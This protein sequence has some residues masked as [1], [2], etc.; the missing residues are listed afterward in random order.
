MVTSNSNSVANRFGYGG[1]ELQEGLGLEIY[2]FGARF[3]DPSLGRWFVVDALADQPEQIDKS[4]YA[5]GW[6]NPIFY[7]DPD[8][9]CPWCIIMQALEDTQQF[10]QGVGRTVG[11]GADAFMSSSWQGKADA[12]RAEMAN[13]SPPDNRTTSF[14][15]VE[16]VLNATVV[17]VV[18]GAIDFAQGDFEGVGYNGTKVAVNVAISRSIP[19]LKGTKGAKGNKAVP[20]SETMTESSVAS[21]LENSSMKTAQTS[22]SFP[23]VK[24]YV[25]KLEAGSKAPAI[26]VDNGVIVEGNHR[27]VA[28]RVYGVEPA[29]VPGTLPRGYRP[30]IQP[31]ENLKIDPVDYGN[32]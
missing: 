30:Y 11:E 17:P 9:N 20:I 3:Q 1:K 31:V 28:G 19:G 10:L 21:A 24:R 6:N 18:E 22:V 8:G 14:K 27:F 7:T 4:P 2:D 15:A 12:I 29:Q 23:A 25:K 16:A 13:P 26:K 5:Y 32:H